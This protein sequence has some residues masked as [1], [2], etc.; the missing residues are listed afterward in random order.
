MNDIHLACT[1]AQ[2]YHGAMLIAMLCHDDSVLFCF[3]GGGRARRIP[4]GCGLWTV[5]IPL[6]SGLLLFCFVP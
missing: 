6:A 2:V 1:R 3:S 5:G 4:K